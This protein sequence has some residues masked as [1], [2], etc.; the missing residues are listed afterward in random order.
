MYFRVLITPLYCSREREREREREEWR[1]YRERDEVVKDEWRLNP[2]TESISSL[3]LLQMMRE[4]GDYGGR[5]R[6]AV[7]SRL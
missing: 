5:R 1:D 6:S 3:F 7:G 4:R 2:T